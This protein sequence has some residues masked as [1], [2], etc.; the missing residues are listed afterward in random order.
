VVQMYGAGDLE[1]PTIYRRRKYA[2]A[3]PAVPSIALPTMSQPVR[4]GNPATNYETR[5]YC[6][7]VPAIFAVSLRTRNEQ[8]GTSK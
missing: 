3:E 4:A 8:G 2:E 5:L 6:I 7:R 1:H